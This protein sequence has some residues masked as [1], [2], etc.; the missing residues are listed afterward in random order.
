MSIACILAYIFLGLVALV[1][2]GAIDEAVNDGDYQGLICMVG[3][4]LFIFLFIFSLI[5]LQNC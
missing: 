4:P 3:I 2:V 5:T 1:V